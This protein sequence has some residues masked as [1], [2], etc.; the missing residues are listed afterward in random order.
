MVRFALRQS[1]SRT[2]PALALTLVVGFLAPSGHGLRALF[3]QAVAIFLPLLVLGRDQRRRVEGSRFAM[4]LTPG[5]SR[6]ALFELVPGLFVSAVWASVLTRS[7]SGFEPAA[8]IVLALFY[9]TVVAVSDAFDRRSADAGEASVRVMGALAVWLTLPVI[10]G[11]IFGRGYGHWPA[12]LAVGMN[13][14]GAV[15]AAQ[16]RTALQDPIFYTYTWSGM[17]DARPLPWGLTALAFAVA[18]CF[19]LV[20]VVFAAR[21]ISPDLEESSG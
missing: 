1:L 19:A 13:P 2:G 4:R 7:G 14:A 5:A 18:L 9:F 3:A 16:G 6:L 21:S 8:A 17:V 12:T 15:L 11:P 20:A 10:L